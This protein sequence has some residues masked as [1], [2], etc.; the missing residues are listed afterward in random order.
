MHVALRLMLLLVVC[1][2]LLTSV[3]VVGPALAILATVA[4]T[5]SVALVVSIAATLVVVSVTTL[6]VVLS[7]LIAILLAALVL[8]SAAVVVRIAAHLHRF[9]V[10]LATLGHAVEGLVVALLLLVGSWLELLDGA[11]RWDERLLAHRWLLGL[12]RWSALHWSDGL[13]GW[14]H[15]C[16]LLERRNRHR[17][18]LAWLE[19]LALLL[20]RRDEG[21][22]SRNE[23]FEGRRSHSR[24]H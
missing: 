21:L 10:A 7:L 20:T 12:E 2:H 19:R 17:W 6:V 5:F 3:V 13:L 23:F 1:L 14:L 16:L 15:S 4:T 11:V 9:V 18:L 8:V 22:A 24:C